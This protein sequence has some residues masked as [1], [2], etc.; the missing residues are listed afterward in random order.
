MSGADGS[1]S[2]R[3][4]RAISSGMIETFTPFGVGSK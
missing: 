1:S 3:F 2:I 4:R